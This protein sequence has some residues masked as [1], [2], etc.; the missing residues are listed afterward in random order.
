[1]CAAIA[2]TDGLVRHELLRA[3]GA[4]DHFVLLMEWRDLASYHRWERRLRAEGHPSALRPFQDRARPG[5]HYEVY[6]LLTRR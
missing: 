5:G 1:V 4:T 3:V 6:R 2:G